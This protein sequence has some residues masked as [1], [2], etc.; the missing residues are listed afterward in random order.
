M[1]AFEGKAVTQLV[2]LRSALVFPLTWAC[3]R[4]WRWALWGLDQG[5]E[6]KMCSGWT[7]SHHPVQPLLPSVF[8][9]K[10]E[11]CPSACK[12]NLVASQVTGDLYNPVGPATS[13][14]RRLYL[15]NV[16][17]GRKGRSIFFIMRTPSGSFQRVSISEGK[18]MK[19]FL[20]YISKIW[21]VSLNCG[22]TEISFLNNHYI[23][24]GHTYD[25]VWIS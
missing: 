21:K 24:E 18:A 16:K 10:L 17:F 4:P 14:T 7:N 25:S 11:V 5:Q 12:C 15:I 1:D 13:P 2:L 8:K 19:H 6:G 22:F 9:L 23:P 20:Q 3:P